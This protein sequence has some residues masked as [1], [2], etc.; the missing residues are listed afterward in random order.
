MAAMGSY[1]SS[2]QMFIQA[3]REVDMRRVA[4]VVAVE[5]YQERISPVQYAEADAKAFSGAL[6]TLGFDDVE[7]VRAGKLIEVRLA[8]PDREAA[9]ASV[10]QMCARLL[11]NPVIERYEFSLSEA[12]APAP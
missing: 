7:S 11:A 12:A 6:A 2:L 1:D 5:R 10:D 4:L 8:A 9:A 3:P